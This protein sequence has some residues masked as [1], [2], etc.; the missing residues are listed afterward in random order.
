MFSSWH[1]HAVLHLREL[2][3]AYYALVLGFAYGMQPLQDSI[4][5][6]E[7]EGLVIPG[8]SA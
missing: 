3:L 2:S 4:P 6:G 1:F 7:L 8:M 5:E